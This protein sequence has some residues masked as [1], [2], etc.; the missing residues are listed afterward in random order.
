MTGAAGPGCHGIVG[1]ILA[2]GRSRRMGRPKQ[3]LP[4]PPGSLLAGTVVASAFDAI[5]RYCERM[6]VVV[7]SDRCDVAGAL[8][9]RR[10]DLV[11]VDSGA[12]MFRSICAAIEFALAHASQPK[13][14]LLQPADHPGVE[15]ST[16]EQLVQNWQSTDLAVMP[17]Y[18]G[19]GGH[20]VLIPGSL[21][22]SV[23]RH[24]GEGGLRQFWERNK[25]LRRRIA[26]DDSSCIRDVDTPADYLG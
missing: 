10:F 23:L 14:I 24:P 19:R 16:I 1:V 3:T 20:P 9:P 13:A 25:H 15:P 8:E 18:R 22:Q 11:A 26:V 2:A 4:W 7:G 12:E 17:E 5:A 6:I 21:L